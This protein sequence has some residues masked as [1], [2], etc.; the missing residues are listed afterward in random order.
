MSGAIYDNNALII[1]ALKALGNRKDILIVATL[2]NFEPETLD[3]T[4]PANTRVTKFFPLDLA[5]PYV[6]VLISNGGFGTVQQGLRAGT[7][8]LLSGVGQDKNQT[9][10]ILNYVGNGIYHPVHQVDP[11]AL[12]R[13][14]DELLRNQSYRCVCVADAPFL[15]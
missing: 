3:F 7:P 5:L 12:G 6:D 1:P 10:G 9:G 4:I 8:M 15:G 2:V 11:E 14:L 13:S